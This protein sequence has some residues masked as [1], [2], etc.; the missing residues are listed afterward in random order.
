M[1]AMPDSVPSGNAEEGG[2]SFHATPVAAVVVPVV[3]IL[4]F[5]IAAALLALYFYRRRRND[6]DRLISASTPKAHLK[7]IP[8]W[9]SNWV[10]V[11]HDRP[12]QRTG[13]STSSVSRVGVRR[14][15]SDLSLDKSRLPNLGEDA[16]DPDSDVI[17]LRSVGVDL[18]PPRPAYDA[19]DRLDTGIRPKRLDLQRIVSLELFS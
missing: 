17:A 3:L 9:L 15:A 14:S 4:L 5:M 1:A 12:R 18:R 11:A 16:A 2:S 7:L 8:T 6:R 10:D 19:R 13:T